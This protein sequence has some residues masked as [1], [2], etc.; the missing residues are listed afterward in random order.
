MSSRWRVT[1]PSRA[2]VAEEINRLHTPLNDQDF[3]DQWH[4]LGEG[5]E[6]RVIYEG[7]GRLGGSYHLYYQGESI[8]LGDVTVSLYV[9]RDDPPSTREQALADIKAI[10]ALTEA[11]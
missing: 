1:A 9:W 2:E 7:N 11:W 3:I 5:D 6:Q 8:Y 10:Y 4:E